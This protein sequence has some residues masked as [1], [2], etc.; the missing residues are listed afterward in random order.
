MR[1]AWRETDDPRALE[2]LRRRADEDNLERTY[3]CRRFTP[4]GVKGMLT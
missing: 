1:R 2:Q 4:R 3:P